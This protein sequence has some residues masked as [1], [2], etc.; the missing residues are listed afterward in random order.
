MSQ[1]YLHKMRRQE[2]TLGLLFGDTALLRLAFEDAKPK[3]TATLKGAYKL[4]LS[5]TPT[6]VRFTGDQQAV[7][8]AM[9]SKGVVILDCNR[10]GQQAS[11]RR[12]FS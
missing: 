5:E 6:H 7:V 10:L 2:L 9:P 1:R 12:L 11:S 4:E 3:T 8:V